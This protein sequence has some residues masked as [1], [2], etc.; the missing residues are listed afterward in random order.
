MLRIG[1]VIKEL[2]ETSQVRLRRARGLSPDGNLAMSYGGDWESFITD[3]STADLHRALRILGEED[4]R[5]V[6]YRFFKEQHTQD[7]IRGFEFGPD[8]GV[9]RPYSVP[10][11]FE[12]LTGWRGP[13]AVTEGIFRALRARLEELGIELLDRDDRVRLSDD[14]YDR[15][16]VNDSVRLGRMF[17]ESK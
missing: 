6:A 15:A 7:N 14:Q 13:G 1:D 10:Q 4:L 9:S 12:K 5:V 16:G 17:R 11:V 8:D 3:L 2:P